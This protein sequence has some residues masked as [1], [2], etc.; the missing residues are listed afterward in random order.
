[1]RTFDAF[2]KPAP[3]EAATATAAA[4]SFEGGPEEPVLGAPVGPASASE[5][6]Q[7]QQQEPLVGETLD[8]DTAGTFAEEHDNDPDDEAAAEPQV[9]TA[10]IVMEQIEVVHILPQEP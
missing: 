8:S 10:Q 7:E 4:V 9:L 6:P 3:S 5:E 1:V 2:S